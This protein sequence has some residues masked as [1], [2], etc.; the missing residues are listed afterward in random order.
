MRN[1]RIDLTI[2]EKKPEGGQ[3][4]II[5]YYGDNIPLDIRWG[6]IDANL[7]FAII[8]SNS[9]FTIDTLNNCLLKICTIL[10]RNVPNAV[11]IKYFIRNQTV[12]SGNII[13][14]AD[15]IVSYETLTN[16]DDF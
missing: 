14:K 2:A 7:E 16:M 5:H 11:N 1:K 4:C 10:E 15:V 13:A 12:K 9:G 8:C 6:K 3:Q